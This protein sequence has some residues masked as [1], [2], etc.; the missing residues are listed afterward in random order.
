RWD[1]RENFGRG[2]R[3]L[4]KRRVAIG[5]QAV[6]R[7]QGFGYEKVCV[8]DRVRG[9]IVDVPVR[10]LWGQSAVRADRDCHE[11]VAVRAHPVYPLAIFVE[12]FEDIRMRVMA[13][14]ITETDAVK[15]RV[16]EF[17]KNLCGESVVA[18]MVRQLDESVWRIRADVLAHS[19][20]TVVKQL[21]INLRIGE[22]HVAAEENTLP[23]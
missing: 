20:D 18:P 10:Q 5:A 21:A 23:V 9:R 4:D 17:P 7:R 19:R 8:I 15:L 12:Q 1:A 2:A 16:A 13:A 14:S 3:C 6:C 22:L 11:S